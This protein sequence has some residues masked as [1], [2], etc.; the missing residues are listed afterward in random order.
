MILRD[1]PPLLQAYAIVVY[2]AVLVVAA[3]N[4][5]Y[6]WPPL[7]RWSYTR[8]RIWLSVDKRSNVASL[9]ER[10]RLNGV[11]ASRETLQ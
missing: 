10:R 6:V 4:L 8:V 2:L 11:M 3:L 7:K 5:K 1:L 9:D